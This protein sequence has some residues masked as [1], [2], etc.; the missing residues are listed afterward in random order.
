MS[1][2][3]FALFVLFLLGLSVTVSAKP[4]Q[5]SD[6]QLRRH[7]VYRMKQDLI[8]GAVLSPGVSIVKGLRKPNQLSLL[9]VRANFIREL[10]RSAEDL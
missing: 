4:A 8:T 10:I 9:K 1:T 3:I 5:K 2:R 7:T 6:D